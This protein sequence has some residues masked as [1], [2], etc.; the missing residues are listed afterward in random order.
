MAYVPP[1]GQ[2]TDPDIFMENVK[3]ADQLISGPAGTVPDRGG[4]PL[5]TWRQMMAKNDEVRQNLIPLSKQYMTLAAAQADIAN[6]P[7]GSTT[8]VRSPDDTALAIEYMN[9]DGTLV[10]TGREMISRGYVDSGFDAV[11]DRFT[12]SDTAEDAIN[13]KDKSGRRAAA[14]LEDGTVQANT[15]DAEN[16]LTSVSDDGW[17]V[18]ISED[19]KGNVA[20]GVDAQG[21]T[22]ISRLIA[23]EI[24]LE[25]P[26]QAVNVLAKF[27]V[28]PNQ[29]DGATQ[30]YRIQA[31][32]DFLDRRGGEGV[33]EL[34]VDTI[35]NPSTSTWVRGSALLMHDNLTLSLNSATLKLADGVFDNIIRNKGIVFDPDNPNGVALELNENR[36]V[37]IIGSGK[38]ECFIEGPDVPYTAPH[39]INGGEPVEWVGDFFGWRTIGILLANC[40]NYE[41]SGFTMRKTTCW[42]ISQERGCEGMHLH[43]IGFDTTVKN[44]DGID[45]RMGCRNG[46]VENISGNTSDDTVAMTA[47]LNWQTNYPSGNYIWPLQVSGDASH[48][49]GDDI[50][51]ITVQNI[52][53]SSLA[54]QVRLLITNG[55][56]MNNITV[57]D[58]EDS[59][60][61]AVTQV[62]VQTGAYGAPSQ[63]GDMTNITVNGIV[64][65]YSNLSLNIDIPIK[66][67][68]FNF[69][70]QKKAGGQVYK[71]NTDHPGYQVV[72]TTVTNA[73]A[74]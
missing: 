28:S 23:G 46:L 27:T 42:G 21:N 51:N 12:S 61:V 67:S 71:L 14:L 9:V 20:A 65:N 25:N 35:S 8:Y 38:D 32:L 11:N 54:N 45:F 36:N 57:S 31:A 19:S 72:N 70:R 53:S 1:V 44:G 69:I 49:L 16:L 5:D 39:P 18:K 74:E 52:K 6:I 56:K 63:L 24:V 40:K 26:V 48:P 37:K 68:Q 59:G 41:M 3:R 7:P 58:I 4:E 55:A 64:S 47:L 60:V 22:R 17:L 10:P 43:D 13:F 66:D 2:T 15:L 29:F 30:H 33:L 73:K 50:E 62:I 34:G